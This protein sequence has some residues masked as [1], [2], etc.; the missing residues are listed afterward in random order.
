MLCKVSIT[1]GTLFPRNGNPQDRYYNENSIL[2]YD[3]QVVLNLI[4][5][6]LQCRKT[7]FLLM[8]NLIASIFSV[9]TTSTCVT[10]D[11][12]WYNGFLMNAQT[13]HSLTFINFLPLHNTLWYGSLPTSQQPSFA[14]FSQTAKA[15]G[16][17]NSTKNLVWRTFPCQTVWRKTVWEKWGRHSQ[18]EANS[19]WMRACCWWDLRGGTYSIFSG[20]IYQHL[21]HVFPCHIHRI[22]TTRRL[23]MEHF[24]TAASRLAPD[25]LWD[26][27]I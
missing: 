23:H 1:K 26:S 27:W 9:P 8:R 22:I 3:H 10:G 5:L 2:W 25:V 18:E 7:S 6:E 21:L 17:A 16:N 14:S 19:S 4:S 12:N 11:A 24:Q 15:I 13:F 20:N